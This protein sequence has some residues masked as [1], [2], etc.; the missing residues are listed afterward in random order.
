MLMKLIQCIPETTTATENNQMLMK[1]IQCIPETT[2]A[3]ENNQM[4][5]T[6]YKA[7][8]HIYRT[9]NNLIIKLSLG[10]TETD[11]VASQDEDK[12]YSLL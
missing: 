3:T 10:S 9:Q 7:I 6:I 1:L 2:T 8:G 12:T 11:C 4:L 5:M